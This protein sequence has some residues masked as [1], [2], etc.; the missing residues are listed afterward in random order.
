MARNR[1]QDKCYLCWLP[2]LVGTGHFQREGNG[3][4]TKHAIHPGDGR[5]TCDMAKEAD[6]KAHPEK[7]EPVSEISARATL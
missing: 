1:Y 6:Q 4:L 2:V 7:Y 3:W 5:V